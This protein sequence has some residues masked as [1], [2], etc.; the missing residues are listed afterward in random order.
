MVR[1]EVLGG[2]LD[3]LLERFVFDVG[4]A[5]FGDDIAREIATKLHAVRIWRWMS[6]ESGGSW[7]RFSS[8]TKG[9]FVTTEY[10]RR[11]VASIEVST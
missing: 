2:G 11:S 6:S 9:P 10:V 3:E 4:G 1:F 5:P 8:G 7:C